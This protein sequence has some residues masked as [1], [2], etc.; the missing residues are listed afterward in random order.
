[1]NISRLA[2]AHPTRLLCTLHLHRRRCDRNTR[3]RAVR[4]DHSDPNYN[5]SGSG[6][7]MA[8]VASISAIPTAT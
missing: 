4:Y 3:C 1:L 2:I 7:S 6:I 8:V 5:G